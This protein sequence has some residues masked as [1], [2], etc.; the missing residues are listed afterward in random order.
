MEVVTP[1][2]LSG[3]NQDDAELRPPTLKNLMR[4]WYRSA[5]GGSGAVASRSAESFLFGNTDQAGKFRPRIGFPEVQGATESFIKE[6]YKPGI[7]YFGF[8]LDFQNNKRVFYQPGTSFEFELLFQPGVGLAGEKSLLASL[9]LLLWLGG[10]GSRSRRGFGSLAVKESSPFDEHG[11]EFYYRGNV[12]GLRHFL[13]RN[14]SL[15]RSWV[16][17]VDSVGSET[18]L[19]EYSILTPRYCSLHLWR[20]PFPSWQAAM[21]QAGISMMGFRKANRQPDYAQV[22]SVL[23]G[24]RISTTPVNRS[25]FGLPIEFYFGSLFRESLAYLIQRGLSAWGKSISAEEAQD[26]INKKKKALIISAMMD[27]GLAHVS[28][29]CKL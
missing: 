4:W 17:P 14:L 16:G 3:A 10:V 21:N 5:K 27:K 25:A 15:A 8:L 6:H 22:K 7:Q 13:E 24:Q 2:F 12:A 11:L 19:P 20:Q 9:W 28:S 1:L 18:G 29:E 23:R 26:I